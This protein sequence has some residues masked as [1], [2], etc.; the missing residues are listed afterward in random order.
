MSTSQLLKDL[1]GSR[2]LIV[3]SHSDNK[4]LSL[5]DS[6]WTSINLNN[7]RGIAINEYLIAIASHEAIYYYNR[8]TG[9]LAGVANI[10]SQ[11]SHEII[12]DP[13]GNLIVCASYRSAL[14]KQGVGIDEIYWSVPGVTP[15]TFDA[16]SWINGVAL[17]D[18]YPKYVSVLGL[19]DIPQGWRD[20]ARISK[21]L[22]IDVTNNNIV[23]NNLFFPH[24]PKIIDNVL[25]FC[26]SGNSQLCKWLPGDSNYTVVT[27]L[28]GWSRGIL[29][30]GDYVLVGIS[31]GKLTAFPEITAD[32][33]AQPGIAI[34]NKN[35][36]QQEDFEPL[37]V[38]E[39]F[40]INITDK[41][42]T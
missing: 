15:E 18:G 14:V 41:A 6:I 24:S 23:L 17:Q 5:Q 35:T 9:T 38:Q 37:D 28:S 16:R 29:Q 12:Y 3:S 36:G 30:I 10:Q 27:E 2:A 25:W 11:D 20:E 31:Q 19:S 26:N 32:P 13:E 7:A 40:D 39:I 33:M 34:I 1:I 42:L 4:I 21:G 8:T 22:I